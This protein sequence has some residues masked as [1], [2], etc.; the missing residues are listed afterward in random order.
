MKKIFIEIPTWLGDATMTTP[1]IENIKQT[2]PKSKLTIFGSYVSVKIFLKHP[3]IDNIIIDDSKQSFIR[4]QKLHKLAKEAG[5]FDIAFSFRRNFSTKFLLFFIKTKKRFIYKR[6]EKNEMH[7]VI[8]YNDFINRSLNIKTQ[9]KELKIYHKITTKKEKKILG[10]NPGATYGSAKRWYALEFAKVAI[11]LSDKY[12]I[13]IFGGPSELDIALDIEKELIKSGTTNY[14]NLAGKTTITE[15]FYHISF[16][17]MFITADSGP[18]HVAAAFKV[19]TVSVFGPT[20]DTETS[21]WQ[22]QNSSILKKQFD[23]QPC[24]KRVCPLIG[25]KYHQCM[26]AIVA[27]DV[28]DTIKQIRSQNDR[29]TT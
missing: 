23:C 21:Q 13:K 17:D 10:I 24:M 22:N 27:K 16:L 3:N 6:Y 1:A 20:K 7:Q 2:Y 19:P 4:Y 26:K 14:E 5:V 29:Q 8:R 9:P 28:L 25:D 18:M 15:L 12:D 11:K